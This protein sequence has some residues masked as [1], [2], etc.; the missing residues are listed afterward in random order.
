MCTRSLARLFVQESTTVPLK[1]EV[2]LSDKI[3]KMLSPAMVLP[4]GGW[5][6]T[7]KS[8]PLPRSDTLAPAEPPGM[9]TLPVRAPVPLGTKAMLTKQEAFGARDAPQVDEPANR[10]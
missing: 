1:P 10:R 5:I 2:D 9:L 4:F 7:L 3:G 8:V 6:T